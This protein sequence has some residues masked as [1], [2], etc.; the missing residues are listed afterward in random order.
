MS[1][2][3]RIRSNPLE[4]NRCRNINHYTIESNR[5]R[6]ESHRCRNGNQRAALKRTGLRTR[7]SVRI[8]VVPL[9]FLNYVTTIVKT[10]LLW[11][12]TQGFRIRPTGY[13]WMRI[14]LV[15]SRV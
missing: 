1:Q 4:S 3:S 10:E 7:R 5:A 12:L 11:R 15:D 6:I 8:K 2:R 13:I 14:H 9:S